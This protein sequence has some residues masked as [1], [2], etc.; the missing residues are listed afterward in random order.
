M[1]G[2]RFQVEA[3]SGGS[4]RDNDQRAQEKRPREKTAGRPTGV[5]GTGGTELTVSC[6]RSRGEIRRRCRRSQ[7]ASAEPERAAYLEAAKRRDVLP[8]GALQAIIPV[9]A[10]RR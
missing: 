2:D 4:C 1:L 7:A 3:A 5:G 9:L 6:R 10:V 8:F